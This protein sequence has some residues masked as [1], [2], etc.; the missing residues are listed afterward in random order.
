MFDYTPEILKT[1]VTHSFKNQ[2]LISFFLLLEFFTIWVEVIMTIKRLLLIF[3][4]ATFIPSD[5]SKIS[6]LSALNPLMYIQQWTLGNYEDVSKCSETDCTVSNLIVAETSGVIFVLIV[7][8]HFISLMTYKQNDKIQLNQ[9]EKESKLID[10]INFLLVNLLELLFKIFSIFAMYILLNKIMISI[11]LNVDLVWVIISSICIVFFLFYYYFQVQ[12]VFLYFKLDG[13]NSLHYDNLTKNYDTVFLLVKL[14][15]ALNKNL[16]F[17]NNNEI[18]YVT[19]LDY[20]LIFLLFNITYKFTREILVDKNLLIVTNLKLN[21]LRLFFLIYLCSYIIVFTF[22]NF[23]SIYQISITITL[24]MFISLTIITAIY[25]KIFSQLYTDE[26]LIYQLSYLLNLLLTDDWENPEFELQLIKIRTLHNINCNRNCQLCKT[27]E[28][29]ATH[30]NL[31]EEKLNFVSK[32]FHYAQKNL[33]STYSQEEYELFTI[34]NLIFNYSLTIIN[35]EISKIKIIYN[36]KDLLEKNKDG[37]KN[38]L[39]NLAFLFW[40]M[41][42]PQS[43]NSIKKFDI[44]KKYDSSI[45]KINRSIQI[46]E[47]VVLTLD[48]KVK[49]DLY[50]LTSELNT[51][52]LDIVNNLSE[53][54]QNKNLYNDIFGFV[55]TR[56]V[57]EKTFN[58]DSGS[59]ARNLNDAEEFESKLDFIDDKFIKD[60]I[61]ISN[62]TV[63]KDNLL[64]TRASK[65]F[66]KYK[67]K[68][69]E[70]IFPIKYRT[71]GR[72]KLLECMNSNNEHFDFNFLYESKKDFVSSVK[73]DT[74]IYRSFDYKELFI[75]CNFELIKDDVL[76]FEVP[77]I[78]DGSEELYDHKNAALIT[79]SENLEKFL[80][81]TPKILEFLLYSNLKKRNLSFNDIFIKNSERKGEVQNF[82]RH[83]KNSSSND[84]LIDYPYYYK[85]F[86]IDIENYAQIMENEDVVKTVSDLK[87]LVNGSVKVNIKVE[88]LYQIRKNMDTEIFIY[89]LKS[90]K[91]NNVDNGQFLLKNGGNKSTNNIKGVMDV[92]DMIKEE[93]ADINSIGGQNIADIKTQGTA[94]VSSVSTTSSALNMSILNSFTFKGKK[95]NLSSQNNLTGFRIT[96]LLINISLGFYCIIFLII[97]FGSND[98]MSELIDLKFNFNS[99]ERNFYQSCLSLFYNVG[100]YSKGSTDMSEYVS[101]SYWNKFK[102][103]GLT[104]NM[105]EYVNSELKV[106]TDLL[107][108]KLSTLQHFIFD[109]YFGEILER[110]FDFNTTQSVIFYTPEHDIK[111]NTLNT[112][113]FDTIVM[114]ISN[115][116]AAVFETVNTMIYIFNYDIH[117]KKYDFSTI[118]NKNISD[119]QKAVYEII[120][121][122]ANYHNNLNRIWGQIDNLFKEEVDYIFNQNMML[123]LI[124]IG[125]HVFLILVSSAIINFLKQITAETNFVINKLIQGEWVNYLQL[126]LFTLKEI[127]HF[128][129]IDPIKASRKL[130]QEQ[131]DS[132]RKNK[133][134]QAENEESSKLYESKDNYNS[135]NQ[136]PQIFIENLISPL[137]KVLIYL[138]SFYLIYSF[139][140]ILLFQYAYTEIM[141]TSDFDSHY[142]KVEKGIMNSI[143][144]L[145]CI[146]PSNQTDISLQNFLDEN[147]YL[148]YKPHLQEGYIHDIIEDAKLHNKFISLQEKNHPKLHIVEEEANLF[149]DCEY[150]YRNV[151][152]E[153]LNITKLNYP[154][155]VLVDNL[156]KLC[157]H[158][159]IMK[160][161]NFKNL[162]EEAYYLAKKI[163]LNYNSTYGDYTE[164]KRLNDLPDFFDEFTISA[165]LMRPIQEYVLSHSIHEIT[166][167]AEHF[168]LLCM[169]IFMIGNILVEC[170][171]FIV[172]NK[173]LIRRVLIINDEIRCLTLCLAA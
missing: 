169:I 78:K 85:N 137:K 66:V 80:C 68:Y 95:T 16:I 12:Y 45:N 172:I 154:D 171:I 48:T 100:I 84:F 71:L 101:N 74:K 53:I 92:M 34:L 52:K 128:Y 40:K 167:D 46:L 37:N 14:I 135:S 102:E 141:L 60:S 82:D 11:Y 157:K 151:N 148:V 136:D 73:L 153:V 1:W 50:P 89:S 156:I 70:E 65:N 5:D 13:K 22:F 142:L 145:Q 90:N 77:I 83:N 57:L 108:S 139:A 158:Y 10:L 72:Q 147:T 30:S 170:L 97:G 35:P 79:F 111:L 140:F 116:Q 19:F 49:K 2:K 61:I 138:F 134:K 160:E 93:G 130:R 41:N 152:D 42:K 163:I 75:A 104:I 114:F 98:K 25:K 129:K 106:K 117:T 6:K 165:M 120:F 21:L 96:L 173:K 64:V 133:E 17:L 109:S 121:N 29:K 155:G 4:G 31:D 124:L 126:K 38:F 18:K 150:L 76:V 125:L 3:N 8:H 143:M 26:K 9:T 55:M 132:T 23:L 122:F 28:L 119:V 63:E 161:K 99:F 69:L 164:M 32:M 112:Y 20:L 56:Y 168:Y 47:D 87:L 123:S 118:A 105:G 115:A 127:L 81:L 67:G 88:Y 62:Y 107:N 7:L 27:E 44:V 58:V 144:L 91:R 59:L 43:E 39:N 166:L 86:F 51:N 54:F 131:K 149:S 94:S 36:L 113:F 110:I 103:D 15:I 24:V 159:K 162:I 33:L 146:L